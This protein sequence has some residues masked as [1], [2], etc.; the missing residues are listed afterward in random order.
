LH[1]KRDIPTPHRSDR[2]VFALELA[3]GFLGA[4][5]AASAVATAAA[6]VHRDAADAREVVVL[7]GRFTY[8]V[9]NAAGVLLLVLALLGAAVVTSIVVGC[10]RQ[11]RGHRRFTR[12]VRILGPLPGHV[13]ATLIDDA[14]P[15]A[16]C[17]GYLRPRVYVSTGAVELLSVDELEA[18]LLHEQHHRS[19]HD[20]L[21]LACARVL[22]QALFFLPALR[23]LHDRHAELVEQHADAAAVASSG[24]SRALAA[25]L[26]AFE[27]SA[28]HGSGGISPERVDSLL[29]VPMHRRWP[30]ALIAAS[31]VAVALL[32]VLVW[33]ASQVASA[34]ATFNLP[35]L[36]SQ[37][38][39][40]VLALV[41]LFVCAGG[42]GG[43]RAL[44]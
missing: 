35:V 13:G 32:I 17:A 36:S 33:R 26:L 41:P 7:G 31:I 2:A 14:T 23:P 39:M 12:R 10:S 4:L 9:I 28:P 15:E 8:P 6:S 24:Q 34:E 42:L 43:A 5:G 22:T 16:F 18:V 21:R 1:A 38:C 40:L 44:R 27:A 30:V 11:V 20:P 19:A 3:L 25:A 29:G 37:P